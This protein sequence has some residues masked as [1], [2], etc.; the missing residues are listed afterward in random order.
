MLTKEEIKK[1]YPL[2]GRPSKFKTPEELAEKIYD[3][4]EYSLN[5]I[6]EV[7]GKN[8]V[9][10]VNIPAPTTLE[11]FCVFCGIRKTT[12]YA[13][14]KKRGFENLVNQYEAIVEEF[15]VRQAAEGK[16]GNKAEFILKNMKNWKT[17]NWSDDKDINLSGEVG[18]VT[19]QF[20]NQAG[21]VNNPEDGFGESG[22]DGKD[23]NS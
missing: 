2:G 19:V 5:R 18:G 11:A 20:V 23:A 3:F 1:N 6:V 4:L 12:F 15:W 21:G 22:N 9:L 17:S 14:G 16:P 13:Y 7:P 8:E 10:R